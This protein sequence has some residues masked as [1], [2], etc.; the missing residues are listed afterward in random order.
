MAV[1]DVTA[2]NFDQLTDA[3]KIGIGINLINQFLQR[4]YTIMVIPI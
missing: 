3:T 2:N 4:L 1:T